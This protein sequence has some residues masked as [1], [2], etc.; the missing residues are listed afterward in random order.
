MDVR[1]H[2]SMEVWKREAVEIEEVG[3]GYMGDGVIGVGGVGDRE[4][5]VGD[6]MVPIEVSKH[7]SMEG[8]THRFE[9]WK[10]RSIEVWKHG[11][12]E[13]WKYGSEK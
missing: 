3:H 12:T 1:K 5:D 10:C 8:S 13:A 7:R 6:G 9:A 4:R 11:C 2:G